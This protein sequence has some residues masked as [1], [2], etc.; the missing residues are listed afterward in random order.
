MLFKRT[1]V[2][3]YDH[4]M[5]TIIRAECIIRGRVQMVMFRDFVLRK[6]RANN[7]V[8]RV[9]NLHDGSVSVSAEGSPENISHFLELLHKGSLFSKVE[10]V[11]IHY[12]KPLDEFNDFTIDYDN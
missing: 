12:M 5:G 10:N 1:Q 8:G 6:A 3:Y 2:V 7:I 9:K 11:E 4:T